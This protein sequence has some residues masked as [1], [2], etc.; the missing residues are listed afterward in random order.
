V[1]YH[2]GMR[3]LI[4]GY[5]VIR[6][7]PELSGLDRRSLEQGRQALLSL[8]ARVARSSQDDFVVVFDGVRGGAGSPAAWRVRTLF[9][10]PPETAD[11]V[12][13]R[14]AREG[15]AGVAVVTSD[16]AVQEAARRARTAVVS[17]DAFLGRLGA[18][19]SP[20][21]R[22]VE[23]PWGAEADDAEPA[24]PPRPK[25]GNPRRLP[26]RERRARKALDRLHR[27]PG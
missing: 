14:L 8:L 21:G 19:G 12:L 17:A 6:R 18:I 10:R 20:A 23:R 16:R 1:G 27:P 11:D 2:A 4:D 13:I 3:W 15:G 7:D 25:K 9:S 22:P 26:R 5:N 24:S